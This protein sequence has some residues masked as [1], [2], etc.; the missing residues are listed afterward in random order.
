MSR[1]RRVVLA[2]YLVGFP[3]G[4]MVW[5]MLHYLAALSRLGCEVLFLED[6]STW[7]YPYDPRTR[8]WGVD[9]SYAR[10]LMDRLFAAY[11]PGVRWAYVSELEGR[12]HGLSRG[13]LDRTLAR[14]D[15]LL[16]LSGILPLR[17]EYARI[18]ARA[19]IDTDPVFTQAKAANDPGT[20]DY[21]KAHDHHFTYGYL[22]PRGET[23]VPLLGLDWKPVLPPVLL[24]C[25]TPRPGP[26]GAWTTLGTWDVKSR[27]IE[28]GG[29]RYS[30]RKSREFEKVIELPKR[31]PGET[32][33]LAFGDMKEDGE[34]F[35]AHGWTIS[36]GLGISADVDSYRDFIS[37]SRGEFSAAKEQNVALRSGWFSDRSACYLAA[38]RPV[39]IQ[40]CGIGDY[41]PVGQGLF[42]YRSIEDIVEAVGRVAAEPERHRA[43]ARRLAEE[44]FEAT[45]VV[46]AMLREMGLG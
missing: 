44:H 23:P 22:L 37:A 34:R 40:D 35:A 42:V 29:V 43:A 27:E 24:D 30:W 5:C 46:G 12:V 25:W 18:P 21:L 31:L 9:S 28:I 4:G 2:G 41:L 38:G 19:F 16:N 20:L 7:S 15:C 3:L 13:E 33:E 17:Q 14:A 10:S 32:F 26:G 1:P 8:T 11:C 45:A 6:S 36:D 39:I